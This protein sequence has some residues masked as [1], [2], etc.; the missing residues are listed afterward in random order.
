MYHVCSNLSLCFYFKILW[1]FRGTLR[2][3]REDRRKTKTKPNTNPNNTDLPW[4]GLNTV[5]QDLL[6]PLISSITPIPMTWDDMWIIR[7]YQS[8]KPVL[9]LGCARYWPFWR[10]GFSKAVK[11][12]II[13]HGRDKY[14]GKRGDRISQIIFSPI[15]RAKIKSV[16]KLSETIRGEGG[17]GS[18]G[19][20]E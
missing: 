7:F 4:T 16:S 1:T 20:R 3:M 11:A 12:I 18:T 13:N 2:A 5:L 17:F 8:S 14:T 10:F 6:E 15:A 9:W 19:I